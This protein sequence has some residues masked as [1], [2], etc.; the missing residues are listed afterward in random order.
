MSLSRFYRARRAEATVSVPK[1]LP[2]ASAVT[3]PL[4]N[5]MGL[6]TGLFCATGKRSQANG[7]DAPQARLGREGGTYGHA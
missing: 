5:R 3:L 1:D 7:D 2:P 6:P 4:L